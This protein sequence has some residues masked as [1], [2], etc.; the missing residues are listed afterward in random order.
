MR[1]GIDWAPGS[2]I[3]AAVPED[4]ELWMAAVAADPP[5]LLEVEPE[6]LTPDRAIDYLVELQRAQSQLAA[7]EARALVVA[8]GVERHERVVTVLS[9]QDDA[10]RSFTLVDEVRDELAAALRRSPNVISDQ[11]LTARLL[12]GP[13]A[14]TAAALCRGSIT[15]AHARAIAEEAQRLDHDEPAA[16]T[17]SC[18]RLQD[19]VLPHAASATPASTRRLARRVVLAIDAD[20]QERRRRLALQSVNVHLYPE[21]D[22][23]AVLVARLPIEHAARLHAALDARARVTSV[24]CDATLGQLRV[25]ALL[26]A[27]CGTPGET[28]TGAASVTVE[29]GLVIDAGALLSGTDDP[30]I[31]T[32]ALGGPQSVS[33]NA[34][35]DLLADPDVPISLRRLISDP[36][37]GHL[38]DRGRSSYA[39]TGALRAYLAT[40]D[41]T[42]R[43]PGCTR[44]AAR[45]Q[46]DHVIEWDDGGRSD[47]NNLGM[48]CI[49][50]HQLKTH[51]RWEILESRDDGKCVWRS[52]MGRTYTVDPP[53]LFMSAGGT[54]S[55]SPPHPGSLTPNANAPCP[56]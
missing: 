56:F 19:R 17:A 55:L 54:S 14:Q 39:V 18:A 15:S 40:R 27:V 25:Q 37:T 53:P 38:L 36:H 41:L 22:G 10:E 35:R 49:R 31:L 44:P 9:R 29:I 3:D 43:H 32:G 7:L 20:G 33:A 12:A 47:R 28:A 13:L 21:E 24:D 42:C 50:H 30:G 23:L 52:P 4:W 8:V 26:D 5:T 16:F 34:V 45:C 6:T 48:L 46:V 1:N 11:I 51:G 2:L